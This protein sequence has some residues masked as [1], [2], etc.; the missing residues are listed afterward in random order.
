MARDWSINTKAFLGD[1]RGRVRGLRGVRLDWAQ[2]NGRPV[3]K[4]LAGS[5]CPYCVGML[6]RQQ[7]TRQVC[8]ACSFALPLAGGE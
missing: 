4:E 8:P 2:D 3:M 7:A 5:E 6:M 1:D